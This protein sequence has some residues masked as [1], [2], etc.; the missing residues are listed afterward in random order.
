[1][2]RIRT[3]QSGEE[4]TELTCRLNIF[5]KTS[6]TFQRELAIPEISWPMSNST[7]PEKLNPRTRDGNRLVGFPYITGAGPHEGSKLG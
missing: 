7:G 4:E 1:M 2:E 3:D 6:V 5:P